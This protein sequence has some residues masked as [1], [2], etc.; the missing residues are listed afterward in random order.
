[1][2]KIQGSVARWD[3]GRKHTQALASLM[4]DLAGQASMTLGRT[5]KEGLMEFQEDLDS[6]DSEF[7]PMRILRSI[8]EGSTEVQAASFSLF[9]VLCFA[10]CDLPLRERLDSIMSSLYEEKAPLLWAGAG[11][12]QDSEFG[13]RAVFSSTTLSA[14]W[15]LCQPA[16]RIS[17]WHRWSQLI[18]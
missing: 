9:R 1:V 12:D 16:G 8:V 13:S 6:Q 10:N 18:V 11:L 14:W 5:P 17:Q 3:L 15:L 4:E 2:A 7:C